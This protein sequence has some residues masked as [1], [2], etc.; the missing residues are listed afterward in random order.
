M[1]IFNN[2]RAIA[3]ATQVLPT[4]VSVP[5]IKRPGVDFGRFVRG[6]TATHVS[7]ARKTVPDRLTKG[8]RKGQRRLEFLF[9]VISVKV[10]RTL[11]VR[12]TFP[13]TEC[14]GYYLE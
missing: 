5:V 3:A 14:A 4:P 12:G 11:R 8:K 2:P 9:A 13:H 1:P 7:C 6:F 10:A